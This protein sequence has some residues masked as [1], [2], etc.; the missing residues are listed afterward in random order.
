MNDPRPAE[1]ETSNPVPGPDALF[2]GTA[3]D[4]AVFELGVKCGSIFHQ[5]LGTPVSPAT[6]TSLEEA[7]TAAVRIQPGV[8]RVRVT[9]DPARVKEAAGVFGYASLEAQMLE[10]SLVTVHAGVRA[11]GRMKWFPEWSYPLFYIEGIEDG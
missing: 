9:I 6:V 7:I 1:G 5:F 11:S 10:V 3:R 8:E 2:A 4:R